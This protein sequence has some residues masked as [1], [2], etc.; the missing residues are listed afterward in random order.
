LT[1]DGH[2]Y[3]VRNDGQQMV[4]ITPT[5]L[6]VDALRKVNHTLDRDPELSGAVFDGL[7]GVIGGLL[8]SNGVQMASADTAPLTVEILGFVNDR[9]QEHV[10]AGDL[11]VWADTL[12]ERFQEVLEE[13]LVQTLVPVGAM[14]AE[15]PDAR[16]QIDALLQHLATKD[17][18][19][20][21]L[22]G[23]ADALQ[24]I[25]DESDLRPLARSL[26]VAADP[27]NG[28]LIRGIALMQAMAARDTGKALPQL[29]ARLVTHPTQQ[30]DETPVEG[31]MDIMLDVNRGKPGA[32]AARNKA[33]YARAISVVRSFLSD[34]D[35]GLERLYEIIA[36]R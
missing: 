20:S 12:D 35:R 30:N 27:K 5:L 9:I 21:T 7:E 18:Y 25:D 32:A 2:P 22:Q 14:F 33:D 1:R 3:T 10:A 13:P 6:L 36:N 24:L 17:S 19:Q 29:L 11:S 31:L 15:D 28:M 26:A 8:D 34:P 23:L 16:L 4:N